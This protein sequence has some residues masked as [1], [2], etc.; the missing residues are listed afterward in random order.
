MSCCVPDI[1]VQVVHRNGRPGMISL[2]RLISDITCVVENSVSNVEL[3]IVPGRNI[4]FTS[5]SSNGYTIINTVDDPTFNIS[6]TTPNLI[7]TPTT[8]ASNALGSV[9]YNSSTGRITGT[10][11]SG[12][13]I[14]DFG[15]SGILAG[16]GITVTNSST[17][18]TI[19][20]GV[21]PSLTLTNGSTTTTIN[22]N[23]SGL[24][25]GSVGGGTPQ[26][27][28]TASMI[29]SPS[30]TLTNITPLVFPGVNTMGASMKEETFRVLVVANANVTVGLLPVLTGV[31][32]TYDAVP[33]KADTAINLPASVSVT[34][35]SVV[36]PASGGAVPGDIVAAGYT[37]NAMGLPLDMLG[38]TTAIQTTPLLV[39]IQFPYPFS[40]DYNT[41]ITSIRLATSDI[42]YP[43]AAPMLS[44]YV[45]D[46]DNGQV[47]ISV[48]SVNQLGM[49][50]TPGTLPVGIQS[51]LPNIISLVGTGEGLNKVFS[52]HFAMEVTVVGI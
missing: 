37:D 17:T 9:Y 6:V 43:Y 11:G 21:L 38:A 42:P 28:A 33:F 48:D 2:E 46:T 22:T 20:L 5:D 39:T 41:Q 31:S 7:L 15:P 29:P 25:Q 19:G 44:V 52:Y 1:D 49:P 30:T 27:L 16:N 51:L 50:T 14:L 4:F 24:L 13:A 32:F 47:T 35:P 8:A 40:I 3:H 12:Q 10:N 36:F 18:S 34:S 23:S 45:S 26:V